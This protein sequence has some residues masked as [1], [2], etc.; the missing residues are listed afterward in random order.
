MHWRWS[1]IPKSSSGCSYDTHKSEGRYCDSPLWGELEEGFLVVS[2]RY[3][4]DDTAVGHCGAFGVTGE[5]HLGSVEVTVTAVVGTVEDVAGQLALYGEQCIGRIGGTM[6]DISPNEL[7]KVTD[8][9]L[10][11]LVDSDVHLHV[12]S[13]LL[14]VVFASLRRVDQRFSL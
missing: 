10:D 3:A 9:A 13:F 2:L 6:A 11:V 1:I 4:L 14:E 7:G 12:H 5:Q 8:I